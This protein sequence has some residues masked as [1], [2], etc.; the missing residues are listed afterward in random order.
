[1]G[2]T[3]EERSKLYPNARAQGASRDPPPNR[4]QRFLRKYGLLAFAVLY[5]LSPI[6]VIPDVSIPILEQL[7]DTIVLIL[8]FLLQQSLA[9]REVKSQRA[10]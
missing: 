2:H 3:S 1:M 10:E 9:K 4:W 6:D 5:L 8:S 7:D